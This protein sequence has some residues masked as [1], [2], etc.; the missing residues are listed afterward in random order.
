MPS[1][2]SPQPR[3]RGSRLRKLAGA[4]L[5][6]LWT[7]S[8][9]LAA[10]APARAADTDFPRPPALERDVHFWVR[11]Y[12]EITTNAG[13]LHDE[14]NL[15]V[16]YATLHFQPN[17]GS[18]ERE[19]LV[20]DA[21]DRITSALKRIAT[22]TGPLS[23]EDQRI[24]DL[25]GEE[26]TPLRLLEATNH[27]RFQLGQADRFRAGLAR[28]GQWEAHIAETLAR[29]GL[30]PELAVLPHVE[31]S[32]NP[33]AYS[34]VGAA[35]LWQF[36]RSTGRR[37]MRID[38]SVD[39]RLDPFRATEAAAQLLAFNYRLLGTW[40][41]ALTAYN[42][43]AAGMR[44][45]K[46]QVGTDDIAQ[47]VR[48]YKSPSFGFASRNFYV[49][50]LAA[51]EIDRHPEK[52]FGTIERAPEARFQEVALPARTSAAAI[53]HE[54]RIDREALHE[55]NPAL[56][57]AI[58]K[59][60][61]PIPGGYRL[62]V[63][64]DDGEWKP[65]LVARRLGVSSAAIVAQEDHSRHRVVP[66]ETLASL[67]EEYGVS[68]STLADLNGLRPRARLH[69]GTYVRL[70]PEAAQAVRVA[71]R[72]PAPGSGA[73]AS[74]VS[75]AAPSAPSSTSGPVLASIATPGSSI[76]TPAS[77]LA[78]AAAVTTGLPGSSGPATDGQPVA[79]AAGAAAGAAGAAAAASASSTASGAA[80]SGTAFTEEPR[81]YVVQ[82]D[83]SLADI[84]AETGIP[85]A[86]LL[87]INHLPDG[88]YLFQGQQL[89]LAENS[90]GGDLD[91]SGAGG[92]ASASSAPPAAGGVSAE[93]AQRESAE[94]AAAVAEAAKPAAKAQPVS[95]AQEE[96]LGPALGPTAVT[97]TDTTDPN[98]YSVAREGTIVVAA[99]ET[100]GHYAEWLDV[101]A[102]RLRLLNHLHHGR[103]VLM[104]HRVRLDFSH[105]TRDA[106]EAKRREYHRNLEASYFAAHRI[107]GTQIYVAR[108]G[109]SLWTVTQHYKT[110][111]VWLLQQYNP[112]VDFSAM[113]PG[114][115]V[116]VPSVQDVV[117]A[118]S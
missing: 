16:V 28:S 31:S 71:A 47:I 21:R 78:P 56:R 42:H 30:P 1:T 18:R 49:S 68:I 84:A 7:W 44:R 92:A 62:R 79:G 82:N 38:A 76:T 86:E 95:A 63:P 114:T 35:G 37:Y 116:V 117:S 20:E 24:R 43:G 69:V 98:D 73:V 70:P 72:G 93:V 102:T 104:G 87:A 80:G 77:S 105:V 27:I 10:A 23:P 97:T 85:E 100:L 15:G 101:S 5:C 64:L 81:L 83:E 118:G 45:A 48:N 108:R 22:A 90:A 46:D 54:L 111:P 67:A 115:Q 96:A 51:L 36:M 60:R 29:L 91:E 40:P 3:G 32:F 55:L 11:V 50:F 109:D 58:W 26:G 75:A 113:R 17:T 6:A 89:L 74:T 112:D 25:W 4:L 34:K 65:Q 99:A 33:H 88:D 110:L 8:A 39:D 103:T 52:Y 53:E 14:Y 57:P 61:R 107:T 66:G 106:F 12:S 41:L 9:L 94:D 2:A 13:F 59:G 19:L